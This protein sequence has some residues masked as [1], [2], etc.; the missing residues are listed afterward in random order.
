MGLYTCRGTCQCGTGSY[1]APGSHGYE[2][3]DVNWMADAG[4]DLLKVDSCCGSQDHATA[5]S[6]Y[7]KFRD[8][9]N[10]TG[11]HIYFNLCGWEQWYGVPDPALNYTPSGIAN[12]Y[13]IAGD[14]SG[15]GP[16]T[17]VM[18][19]ISTVWQYTGKQSYADSDLLIGPECYVGGQT[20]Q[21][22]RAQFSMWSLFPSNLIISQNMLAWSDY[23]LETYSNEEVIAIN[24]DSLVLPG[25]RIVGSDLSFPCTGS[26]ALATVTA[27]AC[28]ASDTAQHWTYDAA[29]QTLR[30]VNFASQNGVLDDVECATSD[31]SVVAI[32]PYDNGAGSCGGVNQKVS[33]YIIV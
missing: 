17:N 5:F 6:D 21:Q 23:A 28:N 1:S 14:G 10:A 25:S 9:L 2:A 13:R 19:V 8:A 7:D 22:A 26:D 32:Y 11:R 24:Q 15:W 18:N 30:P 12:A 27:E 4:M 29:T 16:L 3:A 20:D 33:V 31:G